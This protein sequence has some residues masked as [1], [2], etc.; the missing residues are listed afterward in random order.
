MHAVPS[1]LAA[2]YTACCLLLV[3]A[4]ARAGDLSGAEPMLRTR[5]NPVQVGGLWCGI[6]LLNE[7]T[8]QITQQYQAFEAQLS[9]K[10]KTREVTGQIEG[11]TLRTDPQRNV[12]LVLKAV[13]DEL[14]I[15]HGTGQFALAQGQGF[16]RAHGGS[17][18]T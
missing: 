9:R 6:G 4:L 17:C 16:A 15:T 5:G 10:G 12:V 2:L 8:L 18:G 14:R 11:S 7:F 3:P 13:N 1:R